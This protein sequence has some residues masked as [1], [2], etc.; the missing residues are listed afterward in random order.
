M[1][2]SRCAAGREAKLSA[3]TEHMEMCTPPVRQAGLFFIVRKLQQC[4]AFGENAQIM[5]APSF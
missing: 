5:T 2:R 3:G 4:K 1:G